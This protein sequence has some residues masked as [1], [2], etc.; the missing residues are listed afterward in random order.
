MT[1]KK[2]NLSRREFLNTTSWDSLTV[3]TKV[4]NRASES[5]QLNLNGDWDV[6]TSSSVRDFNAE[7]TDAAKL[8]PETPWGPNEMGSVYNAM[9]APLTP[10]TI[11]G[12]IWYQGETN[13]FNHFIYKKL[14]TSLIEDWREAWNDNF[15]FYFVQ[16][17]PYSWKT[18]QAW[19]R[20]QE[21][22]L[23]C[24]SLPGTGMVVTNDIGN[25]QNI[26]PDNKEQVGERLANWA[27]AKTYHKTG[28]A[29]S[30]PIYR[31]MKI[32]GSQIR[33]CFDYAEQGLLSRG[34]ELTHFQ[35]AG[36]E[37]V[38]VEAEARI[39]GSTVIVSSRRIKH[40]KAVRFAWSNDAEPNL[41][42][43]EGLPASWFRTD[44]M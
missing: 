9:I 5:I 15:P 31:Q 2:N 7:L 18:P 20:V 38:F 17:A 8:L 25:T 21:A 34:G 4:N 12:V 19:V 39:D 30:G 16:L 1:K 26:H 14:F 27:L 37:W 43:R 13:R 40:P 24:L 32:E 11:K 36:E 29:C 33:V 3:T 35:I 42:N 44:T 10:F 28:I 41:F 23:Q 6:C 22:Q